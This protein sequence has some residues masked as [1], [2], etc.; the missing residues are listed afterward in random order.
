M[1]NRSLLKFSLFSFL[2][3][4]AACNSG[5]KEL[6]GTKAYFVLPRNG[7]MPD[8]FALP[9]PTDLRLKADQTLDMRGFPDPTN[10]SM[11][12]TYFPLIAANTKGWGNNSAIYFR[13][14]AALDKNSLPQTAA[15]SMASAAT[16]FLINVDAGSAA[17]GE[18]IPLVWKFYNQATLF[19]PANTLALQMVAGF[20]LKPATTYAAVITR[21]V[22]D[23]GGYPLGSPRELELV[24]AGHPL[25]NRDE[26]TARKLHAPALDYLAAQGIARN[27]IA[28]LAL[29]TTQDPV[30]EM[31]KIREY[32]YDTMS[33]PTFS[34]LTHKEDKGLFHYYFGRFPSW[35]YQCGLP[36]YQNPEDGGD[37]MLDAQGRPTCSRQESLRFSLTIPASDQP[38]RGWPICLYAHGT[39]GS[40]KTPVNN[41]VALE[42]ARQGIAVI[43]IDQVMHGDRK[44]D[45]VA[46][47]SF[48]N[49]GNPIAARDN[50]RQAA[51]DDFFLTR[52][53]ANMIVPAGTSHTGNAVKFDTDKLY[54]M[55]HSQGAH[56]GPPF[57]AAE[58]RI[59]G[60]VLSAP[61]GHMGL[62]IIYKDNG[63]IKELFELVFGMYGQEELDRF[64]PLI[65][66][67]QLF[68]EPSD[69]V[70]Y[71]PYFFV[72]PRAGMAPKH[73]LIIEGIGDYYV[74]NPTTEALAVATGVVQATP[75]LRSFEGYDLLGTPAQSPPI[76]NNVAGGQVTGVLAQYNPTQGED[77][78]FVAFY[79]VA[80]IFQYANFLG[81]LAKTG[82]ATFPTP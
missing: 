1:K 10:S 60:A 5:I 55:G 76:S 68:L 23:A 80:A 38:A 51:I 79:E 59:K 15:D 82:V 2:L 22:R 77:G 45:G 64:H 39:G 18:R 46:P 71:G 65:N 40:Y 11:I 28:A 19:V 26:E 41:G 14:E 48:F 72:A 6:P 35:N 12:Q 29:F 61:G 75:V 20:S 16:V 74:A 4:I 42:L 58:P 3:L 70:N 63:Q 36:P 30:G 31:F 56:T 49:V 50:V 52:L 66:M 43:G 32:I 81:S 62:N 69:T 27:Q 57:L 34:E 33:A 53:A 9:F 7:E 25:S 44:P 13:F 73:I 21:S 78:H 47:E 54:F 67:I 8:F 37:I 24:K 17:R